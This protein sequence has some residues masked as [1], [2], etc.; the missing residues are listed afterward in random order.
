[1]L[2]CFVAEPHLCQLQEALSVGV[3]ELPVGDLQAEK[4]E[5]VIP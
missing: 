4:T 3:K 5:P 1:M 2:C